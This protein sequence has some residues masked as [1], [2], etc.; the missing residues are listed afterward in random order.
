MNDGSIEF[1]DVSQNFGGH[2]VLSHIDFEVLSDRVVSL[3]GPSG[4]GKSTL[5][6]LIAGL[7]YPTAGQILIDD[8]RVESLSNKVSIGFQEPRLLPWRTIGANVA[9]GLAPGLPRSERDKRVQQLL[10]DV[11]LDGYERHHPREISGG[12]AQ[13]VSLARALARDPEFLLLDEPF[14][15]LDA[16]TRI[17]MQRLLNDLQARDPRTVVL[18]THDVNEALF[19][20]DE[21][22]VLGWPD[23][24]SDGSHSAATIIQRL[25]LADAHPRDLDSP[26]YSAHREMLLAALGVQ[27]A[28][29]TADAA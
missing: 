16:L 26:K 6:R 22:I 10:H 5:L 7:D 3:I 18:V 28:A 11:S 13:R 12:M 15:A 4:C 23:L 9:F 24:A 21:I 17:V 19:L 29:G 14:G 8:E 1:H 20:S 2:Q 27:A 25:R